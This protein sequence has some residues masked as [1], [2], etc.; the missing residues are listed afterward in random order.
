MLDINF[1]RNHPDQVKNALALRRTEAD[2]DGL[3][4]LDRKRRDLLTSVE[5]LKAE[6]NRVSKAIAGMKDAA[7]REPKVREMRTVGKRI[8]ELDG[9]V[10]DVKAELRTRMMEIPNMPD[11]STPEGDTDDDNVTI[12]EVGEKPDLGF[13]PQPH[14]ELGNALGIIDFDR[15]VKLSGSRF[16]VLNNH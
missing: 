14:W 5:E 9:L 7:E 15:G 6:R 3:I 8:S 11:P 4:D 12:R 16:Y 1:I 2:I 13:K 10:R